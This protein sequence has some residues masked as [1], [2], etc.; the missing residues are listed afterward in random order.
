MGYADKT[1]DRVESPLPKAVYTG[2]TDYNKPSHKISDG[3][4]LLE[5]NATTGSVQRYVYADGQ[6]R[7]VYDESAA[8]LREI[9]TTLAQVLTETQKVKVFTGAAAGYEVKEVE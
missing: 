7:K 3:S 6:W 9:A 2:Y 1:Y 8:V 4:E 5:I